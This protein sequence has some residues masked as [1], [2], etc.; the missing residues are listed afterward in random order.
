MENKITKTL[1][2]IGEN[3][4]VTIDVIIGDETYGLIKEQWQNYLT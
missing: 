4:A 1:L 3:G 2:Y